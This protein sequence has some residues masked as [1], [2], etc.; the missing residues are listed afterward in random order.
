NVFRK[1]YSTALPSSAR[2]GPGKPCPATR[3]LANSVVRLVIGW[4]RGRLARIGG[5]TDQDSQV[6]VQV[7]L[8]GIQRKRARR[9]RSQPI[10]SEFPEHHELACFGLA[11]VE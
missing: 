11:G 4:D 10:T 1:T 7:C 5:H 3:S 8:I 9:P 2:V 6:S